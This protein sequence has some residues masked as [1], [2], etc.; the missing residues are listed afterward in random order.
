MGHP[1]P[2][3]L[4]SLK[5]KFIS[6]YTLSLFSP[7]PSQVPW[8]PTSA[9]E[10]RNGKTSWDPFLK[11]IDCHPVLIWK[12]KMTVTRICSNT[13]VPR[14]PDRWHVPVRA[15]PQ[16]CAAAQQR[17]AVT[18]QSNHLLHTHYPP[19]KLYDQYAPF[20]QRLWRIHHYGL[21]VS[22]ALPIQYNRMSEELGNIWVI[23][24]KT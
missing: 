6:C 13:L 21:F 8:T 20:Q 15:C 4:S 24:L 2:S 1:S 16:L 10:V 5:F 3:R 12:T 23:T 11:V 19:S 7:R 14:S 17:G 22:C 9:A 18:R